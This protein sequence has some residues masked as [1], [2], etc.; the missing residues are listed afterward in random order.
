MLLR[1]VR[2][3]LDTVWYFTICKPRDTLPSL[4]IPVLDE[5]VIRTGEKLFT[6]TIDIG[7]ADA[8]IVSIKCPQQS[9]L[10]IRLPQLYFAIHRRGQQQV[11]TFWIQV[12]RRHLIGGLAGY[13][14]RMDNLTSLV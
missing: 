6:V 10:S 1:L 13:R 8:F 12:N 14:T 9:P 11:T 2:V 5:P 4:H 3:E 7:L